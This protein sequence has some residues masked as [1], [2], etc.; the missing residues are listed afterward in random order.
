[1]RIYMDTK[2]NA[3]MIAALCLQ[4]VTIL[5]GFIIPR[6]VLVTFGS[7]VNGLV[8]S[9]TQFLNYISLIEGGIGSVLMTALYSPLNE[10]NQI[11]ISA[12]IV[13]GNNFFKKIAKIFLV[14]LICVSVLYPLIV[15]TGYSYAYVASLS[16]IL[17]ISLFIQYYFSIIWR[18]LLQADRKVYIAS[19]IQIAVIV[20]NTFLTVLGIKI[21]PSIHTVKLIAAFAFVLQPILFNNYIH[22]NYS[23]DMNAKPYQEALH[24]RW[25]GFG[26]NLAAFLNS[27]TDIIVLSVLS[28]LSNVSVYGIYSLVV[29]G[30]KSLITSISAGITPSLGQQYSLKNKS[31]LANTFTKYEN[32]IFFLTFSIYS[33]AIVLIV[34]FAMNYTRGIMDAN[35]NQPFFSVLLIFSYGIFCIREPYVN[36]AYVANSYKEITKYAY[37]EAGINIVFSIIFVYKFGLNGVAFGTLLSMGFRTGIQVLYLQKR[38]LYRSSWIFLRKFFLYIIS[39]CMGVFLASN[40]IPYKG[41]ESWIY[42]IIKATFTTLIMLACNLISVILI[43]KYDNI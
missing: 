25:D 32:L 10:K 12:I 36:M 1:M 23:L 26:I 20:L 13:A 40:L 2:T 14:Y 24:H 19:I 34:P 30:I 22:K 28:T 6:Q 33:C 7:N 3:N 11:R 37:I 42:W 27:N 18:L 43:N 39:S 35:Y 4:F 5:S 16:L 31:I 21:F 41:D 15:N 8:N 38:I 17:G 29:V 9:I